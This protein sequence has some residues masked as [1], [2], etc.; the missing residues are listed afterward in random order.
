ML[1]HHTT[2][3][4]A[5]FLST[6]GS[7]VALASR[8]VDIGCP[9]TSNLDTSQAHTHSHTQKLSNLKSATLLFLCVFACACVCKRP[10]CLASDFRLGQAGHTH[11]HT[12]TFPRFMYPQEQRSDIHSIISYLFKIYVQKKCRSLST[13]LLFKIRNRTFQNIW[14]REAWMWSSWKVTDNQK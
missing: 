4:S 14:W 2:N 3:V 13:F 10:L 12:H 7:V 11:T 6:S 1:C 5:P 8:G 9:L